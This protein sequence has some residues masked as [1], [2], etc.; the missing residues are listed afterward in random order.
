MSNFLAIVYAFGLSYMPMNN[1]GYN[2]KI[3]NYENS[4]RIEFELGLQFFNMFTLYGGENTE[5]V[6]DGNVFNWMPYNQEYYVGLKFEKSIKSMNV[7]LDMKRSCS[8]PINCW[9]ETKGT[10]NKSRFE[11]TFKVSGKIDI[12]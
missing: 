8:H 6:P 11:I 2:D 7:L 3:F 1:V 12:F 10:V 5:Q 4:T 9:G